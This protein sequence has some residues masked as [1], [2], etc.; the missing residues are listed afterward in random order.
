MLWNE[1]KEIL[2]HK[3][4]EA[5]QHLWIDP[6]TCIS[7]DENH[8]ELA[9]PDKFFCLWVKENYLKF[10]E[11]SLVQVAHLAMP[12]DFFTPAGPQRGRRDEDANLLEEEA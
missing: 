10:I 7:A 12:C 4:P 2:K 8:I 1:I 11:E 9:C 3:L 5:V 6:L